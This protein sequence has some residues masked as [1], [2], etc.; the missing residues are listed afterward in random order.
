VSLWRDAAERYADSN[1]VVFK[2]KVFTYRQLDEISERIAGYLR[3]WYP[4]RRSC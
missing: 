3:S 2:D 4:C 1:A